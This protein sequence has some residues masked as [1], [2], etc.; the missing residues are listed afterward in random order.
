MNLKS[1]LILAFIAL[2]GTIT[3]QIPSL[4]TTGSSENQEVYLQSL[5]IKTEVTGT[6]GTTTFTMTFKNRTGK[7]LEGELTFPLPEGVTVSS[8][9]LDI[10]GKMRQAVP[11]E[12]AKA[13]R[14]FE[15]IE[16]RRVDPG[17][18]ERVEGN[19]FR[20]RIY[21]IPANGTR[22]ITIGYEQELP[23][24]NGK[25][26]FRLPMDY[27]EAI[28]HFSLTSTV[29]QSWGKPQ[30][31]ESPE[32]ALSFDKEGNNYVASYRREN[33]RPERSLVFS[34]PVSESIPQVL[35][36]P[37]SG[38][39]YFLASCSIQPKQR[40]KQWSDQL[41]IIWDVSLSGLQRNISQELE[42][43]DI[44]IKEKKNLTVQLYLLN[45]KFK[46]TGTFR[47]QNG[48][49]RELRSIL[50]KTDYDGGTDYT[51][52]KPEKL[53]AQEILFFSDGLSS[54]G[55]PDIV[56]PDH[57]RKQIHCIV[58]SPRADYSSLNRIASRSG[59]KFI[60]LNASSPEEVRTELT[61]ESFRFL[62]I[63]KPNSVTEVYPSLPV[64][65]RENFSIAGIV[66]EYK[67]EITLLFGYGSQVELE[68][69]IMLDATRGHSG[70]N[71]YRMW[72]QKKISELDMDYERNKEE[73]SELGMQFGIVT[74]N[75]SLIVLETLQDYI[76]YGITPPEELLPQ[77]NQWRKSERERQ[78]QQEQNL[79][80][81]AKRAAEVLKQWWNT[82][83]KPV[84]PKYP[85]PDKVA[86][87]Q[88][89]APQQPAASVATIT[90]DDMI[91]EET[92]IMDFGDSD[93]LMKRPAYI[94]EAALY[95]DESIDV[96]E[97]VELEE[98]VVIS[99]FAMRKEKS[100]PTNQPRPLPASKDPQPIIRKIEIKQDSEYM[101]LLTGD[102]NNDYRKYLDIRSEYITTPTF[103]FDMANWFFEH[104]DKEKAL[105]ILTCVA[106]MELENASLFRLLGYRLKEYG[107]YAAAVYICKKVIEWRP[108]EPQSYRDYAL[109]LADTGEKQAALDSLYSLLIKSYGNNISSRSRGIEEVVVTELNQ[110]IA[111]NRLSTSQIDTS[112]IKAMPV[113]IRV[114]MNWN[115]NSTDIDLHVT[116][117][118]GEQCS[119]KH[120]QTQLG[121][122]IS[123]DIRQGYGPEQFMLKK[124][125]K[126]K[127]EVFVN[128]FG[129]SQVKA[130]G[131]STIMLEVYTHYG[132]KQ[133]QRQIIC[134]QLSKQ[135]NQKDGLVKVAE[136][137]F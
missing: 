85:K 68:Q 109:L 115:M 119:Y 37:A 77:Y 116:D 105:T 102:L 137:E 66:S 9:A 73:L 79:L 88:R 100:R 126:G 87:A 107:E 122:R 103:Y 80:A 47:I 16:Q 75:T 40:K 34:L 101:K 63:R 89:V 5:D 108:M 20:T 114:V 8:Y 121:G 86:S 92:E 29:W 104:N 69:K 22:T 60:N 44:I 90:S 10:N 36:Q 54:L 117:P 38:S 33:F 132:S 58:S 59:G 127:Y 56:I 70:G 50:E 1:I 106:D 31:E 46:Q 12:K 41:G 98:T 52:I 118:T 71:I 111:G 65:V 49:W 27:K 55:K 94:P 6:I 30:V 125:V 15:E 11:V 51:L 25:L 18:L 21:P 112:L 91:Q 81:T 19:N 97:S 7:I 93:E 110:L 35:M 53:S 130:E 23:V 2:S 57:S 129:D 4:R 24:T 95:V 133:Q 17:L 123:Q 26:T 131:P 14:V 61:T 13:T 136:F 64:P 67:A 72:A 76:T 124:A 134:L 32:N 128:Y 74:R 84:Q 99:G 28:D 39:H 42:L 113:D 3:A 135:R 120:K 78:L 96:E 48:N 43:L 82:D 62:G 45:N 83:F